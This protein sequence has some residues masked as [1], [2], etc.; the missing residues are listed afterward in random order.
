[1]TDTDTRNSTGKN[2]NKTQLKKK[3]TQITPKQIYPGP[4][5]SY[6]T[7]PGNEV[8]LFYNAAEPK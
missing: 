7:Q 5:A 8:G 1:L 3:T 4:V 6:D 2:T